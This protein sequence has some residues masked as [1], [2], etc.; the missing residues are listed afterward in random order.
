[1]DTHFWLPVENCLKKKPWWQKWAEKFSLRGNFLWNANTVHKKEQKELQYEEHNF[2]WKNKPSGSY[3]WQ[4]W[5][6]SSQPSFWKGLSEKNSLLTKWQQPRGRESS[7]GCKY[8]IHQLDDCGIW[9]WRRLWQCIALLWAVS[10]STIL[11]ECSFGKSKKEF[12][13]ELAGNPPTCPWLSNLWWR[14][15]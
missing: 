13:Y 4:L 8:P 1:M 11:F 14:D 12:L 3:F 15:L 7:V 10:L 2:F 9:W 5:T 6:I